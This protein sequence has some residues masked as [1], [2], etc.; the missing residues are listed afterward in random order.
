[1]SFRILSGLGRPHA[2]ASLP[3]VLASMM[4][5]QAGYFTPS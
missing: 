2:L 4:L 1:M 3:G 5:I